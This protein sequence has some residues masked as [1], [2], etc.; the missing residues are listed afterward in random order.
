MRFWK[1]LGIL[2]MEE[3]K[4]DADD[5]FGK[6]V[7]T[8]M[9]SMSGHMMFRFKHYVSNLIFKYQEMQCSEV[10]RNLEGSSLQP[11]ADAWYS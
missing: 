10:T 11:A 3:E 7:A 9:K 4:D 2:L 8:E 1:S 6:I 5:V